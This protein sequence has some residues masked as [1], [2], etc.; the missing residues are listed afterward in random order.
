MTAVDTV[1]CVPPISVAVTVQDPVAEGALYSPEVLAI[2]PHD[3]DQVTAVVAENCNASFTTT[4]GFIGSISNAALGPAPDSTT[5]CGLPV[6]ESLNDSV[7]VRVPLTVGLKTTLAEQVA[8]APRLVPQVF[9]LKAKS[10]GFAP[11]IATLLMLID[12]EVLFVNVALCGEL[13]DPTAVAGKA[14]EV[15]ETVTEPVGAY[16]DNATLSGVPAE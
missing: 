16:P 9:E 11:P 1:A 2:D 15:G 10:P 5:V 12:E 3:A 6:A 13:V 7:A 8:E 14:S 4:V